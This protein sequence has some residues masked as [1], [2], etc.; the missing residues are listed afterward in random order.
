MVTVYGLLLVEE[1]RN[2]FRKCLYQYSDRKKNKLDL[3]NCWRGKQCSMLMQHLSTMF[4]TFSK[5]K[6]PTDLF[7][8]R[9]QGR[10]VFK[11][12]F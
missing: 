4:N 7:F 5:K 2:V 12:D 9:N 1:M 11:S 8:I 10:T 3:K 6:I